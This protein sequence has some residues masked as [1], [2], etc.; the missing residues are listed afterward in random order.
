MV[1]KMEYSDLIDYHTYFSMTKQ[2]IGIT[3][4]K[5]VMRLTE[6]T[7][8]WDADVGDRLVITMPF[9]CLTRPEGG[10]VAFML[11]TYLNSYCYVMAI[12]QSTQPSDI[13]KMNIKIYVN[14][15]GSEESGD[16]VEVDVGSMLFIS[17]I[18]YKFASTVTLDGRLCTADALG[19]PI[20]TASNISVY[21]TTTNFATGWLLYGTGTATATV[22]SS[23]LLYEPYAEFYLSTINAVFPGR[24]HIY[25]GDPREDYPTLGTSSVIVRHYLM[26]PLTLVATALHDQ[27]EFLNTIIDDLN[28]QLI[29]A[30]TTIDALTLT[31]GDIVSK[32]D[33]IDDDVNAIITDIQEGDLAGAIS[34]VTA[35][36]GDVAQLMAEIGTGV[37]QAIVDRVEIFEGLSSAKIDHIKQILQDPW[38]A[39]KTNLYRIINDGVKVIK[40]I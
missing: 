18:F 27:T 28:D 39:I 1:K 3:N 31:V 22:E 16:F 26:P 40:G 20:E 6:G 2:P 10:A 37:V 30:Q 33:E 24:K 8:D 36:I 29:A 21:N 12:T 15:A 14:W 13:K 4:Y 25:F 32:A 5:E 7:W 17:I 35:L 38:G 19:K 11:H 9:V 34:G 23:W